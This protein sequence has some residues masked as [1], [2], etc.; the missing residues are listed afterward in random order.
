MFVITGAAGFIGS[1]LVSKLNSLGAKDL[2]LVDDFSSKSKKQNLR[3]K[4]F[5]KKIHRNDFV[6][7]LKN[8][9]N[10]VSGIF[11]L[12][13]RTD[14][15]ESNIQLLTDLN[16][17]YS[18]NLWNLSVQ[19]N[20]P[21]IYA[22]SA[23]T[24]GSGSFGFADDHKIIPQLQPLNPYAVSK[25]EFDKWVLLQ[26]NFPPFWSGL[27]LYNV[28]GP[29]ES[30]KSRMSSV[31]LKAFHQIK[32]KNQVHLFR[33]HD[34]RFKDGEQLRDFIYVKDVVD[35]LISM[36]QIKPHSAIYNL[37]TG[38]AR[39][40]IDL[41][42]AVFN[43]LNLKPN[44]FYYDMPSDIRDNYQYYTQADVRKIKKVGL[45]KKITNLEE[46]VNDYVSNYLIT[47]ESY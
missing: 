1:C 6:R 11:H 37:G 26:K 36:M 25:N 28:Y 5:F 29:N 42:I 15:A 44:I 22:S 38:N 12:G 19:N 10:D 13:A 39:T 35:V 14:T 30:H 21:F 18:K 2:L 24:Y 31:V 16:L 34:I 7:W 46:G 47:S 3:N 27:K 17:D 33:S 23:A 40:F 8:N 9:P 43:V 4:F 20:I 45:L 41:V 32:N